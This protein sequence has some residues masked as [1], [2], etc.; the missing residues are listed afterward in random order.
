MKLS[1]L[2]ESFV[3]FNDFDLEF[4]ITEESDNKFMNFRKFKN[5]RVSDIGYSD[6][7]IILEGDEEI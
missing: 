2:I 5:I 4:L 7:V 1:E 3:L 6:K